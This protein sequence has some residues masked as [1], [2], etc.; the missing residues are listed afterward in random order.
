MGCLIALGSLAVVFGIFFV[1]WYVWGMTG[2]WIL[3][4]LIVF[5]FLVLLI[6]QGGEDT[7]D[8]YDD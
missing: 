6:T 5:L 4:G 2:F 3:A 8:Y 1:V 7:D